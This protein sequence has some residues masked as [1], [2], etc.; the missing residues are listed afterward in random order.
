M[1]IIAER[2]G[3]VVNTELGNDEVVTASEL[4]K[5]IDYLQASKQI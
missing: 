2:A 1:L 3:F 5:F 4:M